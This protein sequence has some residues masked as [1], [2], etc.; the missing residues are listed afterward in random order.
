MAMLV[1]MMMAN[2]RLDSG[3]TPSGI[4]ANQLPENDW[5]CMKGSM[6]HQLDK[7]I[8]HRPPRFNGAGP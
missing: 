4:H 7:L 8:Y 6:Q 3:F 5:D 1:M 2:S